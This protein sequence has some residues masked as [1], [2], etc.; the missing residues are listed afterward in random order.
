MPRPRA[1]GDKARHAPA[2]RRAGPQA[3]V[4]V[5]QCRGDRPQGGGATGAR[6]ASPVNRNLHRP[7]NRGSPQDGDRFPH[8]TPS[9]TLPLRRPADK[10][11]GGRL[12]RTGGAQEFNSPNEKRTCVRKSVF[13]MPPVGVEPTYSGFSVQRLNQLSYSGGVRKGKRPFSHWQGQRLPQ[14]ALQDRLGS[15]P[16]CGMAQKRRECSAKRKP[17]GAFR[18]R[19]RKIGRGKGFTRPPTAPPHFS[20]DPSG[21]PVDRPHFNG[22]LPCI[23]RPGLLLSASSDARAP[24]PGA[25]W[26]RG[27]SPDA[28]RPAN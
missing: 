1:G 21:K 17:T 11:E 13:L 12:D 18:Q 5:H 26:P 25:R 22:K 16:I 3:P 24:L 27:C 28:S 19:N 15:P 8:S 2:P 4:Q 20:S 14:C 6:H 7:R 10:G 23:D 9:P